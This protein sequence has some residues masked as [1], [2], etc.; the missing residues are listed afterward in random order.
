MKESL[1]LRGVREWLGRQQLVMVGRNNVGQINGMRFGLGVGSADL[2]G[3]VRPGRALAIE[4]KS[5]KGKLSE[6]QERWARR[7]KALGG[8]FILARSVQDVIDGLREEG[9]Y[10]DA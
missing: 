8:I 3:L 1:V 4:T 2:V 6:D 10:V 7:W 9:I 5:D